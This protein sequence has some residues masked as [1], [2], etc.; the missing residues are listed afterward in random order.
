M[1]LFTIVLSGGP[2]DTPDFY[3]NF[4]KPSVDDCI[5]EDC[6]KRKYE[7]M[8]NLNDIFQSYDLSNFLPYVNQ[9]HKR[10]DSKQMDFYAG[11]ACE[12]SVRSQ[13]NYQKIM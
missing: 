8:N 1:A 6:S 11:C 4:P 2:M 5:N 7:T 12:S 10:K 9:E 3:D 13:I